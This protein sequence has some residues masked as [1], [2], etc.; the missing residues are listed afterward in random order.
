MLITNPKAVLVRPVLPKIGNLK[1]V[2][3]RGEFH[4]SQTCLSKSQFPI[5]PVE[6]FEKANGLF[7]LGMS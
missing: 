1:Y 4:G 6:K 5:G 7:P 3:W 2:Y